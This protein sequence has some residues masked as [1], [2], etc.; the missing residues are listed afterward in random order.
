MQHSIQGQRLTARNYH[1]GPS[2]ASSSS[3]S[4]SC[5]EAGADEAKRRRLDE[6]G[7]EGA[8]ERG[9]ER[10]SE[11]ASEQR[12]E[13]GSER[14]SKGEWWERGRDGEGE[15][16]RERQW[17]IR[18]VKTAMDEV[19]SLAPLADSARG[20]GVGAPAESVT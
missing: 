14:G 3:S 11:Q 19:V 13:G 10:A 1:S 4:S 8:S 15:K 16:G 20:L 17:A 2:R 12:L 9:S 5:Q 18:I 6:P 7:S